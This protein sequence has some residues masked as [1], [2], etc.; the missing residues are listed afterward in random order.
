MPRLSPT[1]LLAEIEALASDPPA[2][3]L[4]DADVRAKLQSACKKASS[5]LEQ[6]TEVITRLLLAQPVENTLVNIA[7]NLELFAR[8][9]EHEGPR[10]LESLVASTKADG[11]LLRRLLRALAAFGAV[12]EVGND[13]Y[14]LSP[15][16]KTLAEPAFGHAVANW[17][18]PFAIEISKR[19]LGLMTFQC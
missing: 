7:L 2:E 19:T 14:E 8:L 17:Y 3:L 12:K 5:A 4:A 1:E 11:T 18:V 10:S 15:Q 16:Y 13:A 6:P 9:A